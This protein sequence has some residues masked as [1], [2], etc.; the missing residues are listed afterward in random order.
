MPSQDGLCPIQGTQGTQGTQGSLQQLVTAEQAA[1]TARTQ[2]ASSSAARALRG[3][4]DEAVRLEEDAHSGQGSRTP[5]QLAMLVAAASSSSPRAAAFGDPSTTPGRHAV[6]NALAAAAA[7]AADGTPTPPDVIPGLHV[8]YHGG[9][10]SIPPMGTMVDHHCQDPY[11]MGSY[12]PELWQRHISLAKLEHAGSIAKRRGPMDEMRQ[13][14]RILSKLLPSSAHLMPGGTDGGGNKVQADQI[15]AYLGAILGDAPKPDWGLRDGWGSYLA[16]LFCWA[17]GRSDITQADAMSCARRQAGRSWEVLHGR[18]MQLGVYSWNW[19]LPLRQA[20]VRTAPR[21]P[22]PELRRQVAVMEAAAAAAAAAAARTSTSSAAAGRGG[23]RGRGGGAGTGAGG[24]D[25]QLIGLASQR[26]GTRSHESD[27]IVSVQVDGGADE[28]GQHDLWRP[29][30]AQED[31]E[32]GPPVLLCA[33]TQAAFD[34]TPTTAL[35][36]WLSTNL[37]CTLTALQARRRTA[38]TDPPPCAQDATD[39]AAGLADAA[40]LFQQVATEVSTLLAGDAPLAAACGGMQQQQQRGHQGGEE[41]DLATVLLLRPL[42]QG[43]GGGAAAGAA[44]PAANGGAGG[45]SSSS[46][47]R[48]NGGDGGGIERRS[49]QNGT[50]KGGSSNGGEGGV[51]GGGGGSTLPMAV[52]SGSPYS[53]QRPGR[54]ARVSGV[55]RRTAGA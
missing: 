17:T 35:L 9:D 5:V 40:R 45:G 16:L 2:Q 25:A 32:A 38:H 10:T 39:A 23:S 27:C 13:L 11:A 34:A 7:A 47:S 24:G 51:G 3:I 26:N 36:A 20:Q 44:P 52:G 33:P 4:D 37:R 41:E 1:A 15:K 29:G 18:L 12:P 30:A 49:V 28:E 31:A 19:E 14:A 48:D 6:L 50:E 43:E 46:C 21:T 42:S 54:T 53:K 8:G 22:P 55:K